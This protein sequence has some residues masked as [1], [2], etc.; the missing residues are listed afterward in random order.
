[1]T[2]TTMLK[3]LW[4]WLNTPLEVPK[5]W[6][7]RV[8]K[9]EDSSGFSEVQSE[10]DPAILDPEEEY[11]ALLRSL[12]R[13]RGFGLLFVRCNPV[14][15]REL[16]AKV[17]RDL[18]QKQAEFLDLDAEIPGGQFYELVETFLTEKL[19]TDVL[20]VQGLEHSLFAYEETKQLAGWS[21]AKL[22]N[23]SWEGVPPVLVN[24]N[25]QRDRFRDSF[26][27]TCLVFLVREFT[28]KYLI[29]RAPDFFDWRSGLFQFPIDKQNLEQE[30][31]RLWLDGIFEDYRS[32]TPEQ[33][34]ARVVELKELITEPQQSPD[35]IADLAF[36]LGNLF[37]ENQQHEE[38][39]VSYE[40]A[41]KHKPDKHEAWYNR[42]N[43]LGNL[44]RHEEAIMSFEQAL[45]HKPDDHEAWFNRG[46]ALGNLGRYE[47]AIVSYNEALKHKPDYP[48]ALYNKSCCYALQN[49][50]EPALTH[51]QQAIKLDPQYR[52]MARSDS[53]FDGIRRDDRFQALINTTE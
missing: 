45:K 19:D 48:E 29:R 17:K 47:E 42:G 14:M 25:L 31:T 2:A 16:V 6:A 50:L 35:R 36:E 13:R 18:P 27:K 1:M 24:L 20:F 41:L 23:Y 30:S 44:G 15:G 5:F 12:R 3:N 26:A 32:W 52:D 46:N 8:Q 7:K 53:D 9:V 28:L 39:I 33:R 10:S 11:Q 21:P 51:L 49:Q 22:R 34:L 37:D 43:A 4:Q 40:E 38:A